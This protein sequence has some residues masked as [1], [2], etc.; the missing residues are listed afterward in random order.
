[1]NVQTFTEILGADYYAGVPD[2]QLKALCDYLMDTYGIDPKH[3]MIGANE[4]NC[5]ALA[6]GYHLA[7]GKSACGLYAKFRRR[8]YHQ[9]GG[10]SAE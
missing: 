1:M 4:G 9:P 5:T 8:K 7:T 6:A 3:H 2:S 10:V